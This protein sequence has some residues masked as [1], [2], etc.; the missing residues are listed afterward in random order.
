MMNKTNKQNK[1][2][3]KTKT[4]TKTQKTKTKTKAKSKAKAMYKTKAKTLAKVK[5]LYIFYKILQKVKRKY[6]QPGR[7]AKHRVDHITNRAA[8]AKVRAKLRYS[9]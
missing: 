3:Q 6:T 4:K 5:A 1:T 9:L 7:P 8:G 2:K